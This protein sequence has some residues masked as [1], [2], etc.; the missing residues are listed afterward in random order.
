MAITQ[1]RMLALIEAGELFIQRFE[2][3][4]KELEKASLEGKSALDL[5][6]I[7]A[8]TGV[9]HPPVQAYLAIQLER[10]HYN[11]TAAINAGQKERAELRRRYEGRA[12][13]R[14]HRDGELPAPRREGIH[15]DNVASHRRDNFA[16][17][18]NQTIDPFYKNISDMIEADRKPGDLAREL[19]RVPE[20]ILPPKPKKPEPISEP[21]VKPHTKSPFLSP[22]EAPIADEPPPGF[23]EGDDLGFDLPVP[24][25][26]AEHKDGWEQKKR[27]PKP[28]E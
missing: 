19:A 23:A 17:H 14:T 12:I 25:G 21:T 26:V 1:S 15:A 5:S 9:L 20:S 28:W 7:L 3:F 27:K 24:T 6:E 16:E 18:R 22:P 11:R 13:N 8:M 4:A 10:N 2:H